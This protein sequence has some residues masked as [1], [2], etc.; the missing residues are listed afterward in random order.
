MV[1]DRDLC[2]CSGSKSCLILGNPMDCRTSGF[3]S[4]FPGV[5]LNE[6]TLSHECYLTISSSANLFFCLQSFPASGTFPISHFFTSGSQSIRASALPMNTKDWFPLG[7]TGLTSC[8]PRDS[9]E[10]FPP[11]PFE[12]IDSLVLSLLYS[13]TLTS[14]N[15]YWKNHSFDCMDL[16]Q[17]SDAL[18]FNMLSTLVTVFLPRSKCL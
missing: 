17:Q 16:C 15:D 1:Q 10:S 6:Y 11:P 9:Q 7:L 2:Y 8:S 5:C 4:P 14:V 13:P 12:N 3:P 18:L